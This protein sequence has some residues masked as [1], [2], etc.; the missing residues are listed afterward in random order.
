ME[1]LQGIFDYMQSILPQIMQELSLVPRFIVAGLC[2]G[3]IGMERKNRAKEAG[4]RTHLIVALASALM[5]VISKYGFFDML[6]YSDAIKL[7][8]SRVANGIV[9]GIG[10]LGAGMIFVRKQVINGLT[11]AAGVWATVGIGMA[12]GAGM[13]VVGL[14]A[15]LVIVLFQVILHKNL[16]LFRTPVTEQIMIQLKDESDS[17]QKLIDVFKNHEIELVDFSAT[18]TDNGFISVNAFVKLPKEFTP[19]DAVKLISESSLIHSVKI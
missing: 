6:E 8:P 5:M 2:G 19:N 18:K 7:D 3:L 9:T 17:L 11:T 10:F 12:F 13:Y 15:T 16:R 1:F 4:I 14:L